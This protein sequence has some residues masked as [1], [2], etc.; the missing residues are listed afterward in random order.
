MT[1]TTATDL[2][3]VPHPAGA[4]YVDDWEL[5]TPTP[6]RTVCGLNR[7]IDGLD[8]APDGRDVIVWTHCTQF[9]DGSID[10]EGRIEAPGV[11]V[12][13]EWGHGLSGPQARQLA[14]ILLEAADEIDQWCEL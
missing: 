11:S 5:Y 14:A 6:A 1:T 12:D 10:T 9:A 4:A 8:Q 3:N 2:A 7:R 13:I